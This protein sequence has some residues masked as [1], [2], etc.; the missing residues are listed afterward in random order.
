MPKKY[1]RKKKTL[2]TFHSARCVIQY[3][4][5]NMTIEAEGNSMDNSFSLGSMLLGAASAA[6]QVEG[7]D[8]N[9]NWYEWY[10]KGHIKDGSDP[11][12]ATL[13]WERWRED[14]DLMAELGLRCCRLGLEWSRIEPEEGVFSADAMEHYRQELRYLTSLGIRPMVTLW[15]FVNPL[16]FERRGAFLWRG[17]K[18]AF[19]TYVRRVCAE[20]GEDV[21]CWIT[22]NEPNVYAV[23]GY[24]GGG[25]PPGEND[26]P[27]LV[28]VMNTLT[29][30][31][32]GAY[33]IIHERFPD[34]RV[35]FA[36]HAR[37]FD[38]L[39]ETNPV[40][41]AGARITEWAFQTAVTRAMFTGRAALPYR[42]GKRGK[43][44]DYI[45]VNYYT[46]SSCSGVGDGVKP[47]TPKNDLDW[48]IYPEGLS[49]VIVALR[50]DYPAPV[51]ITEN[52]TC[53]KDDTFRCRYLYD[54]LR[55]LSAC[56][57]KPER[58]YHWCFCDNFEWLEGMSARFGL[59]HTDTATQERTVKKSGRF[60][61]EIIKNGGVTQEMYEKY[62]ES[63][64]YH[65]R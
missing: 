59:V 56:G 11:S 65:I 41:R 17:A 28:K 61:A 18:D 62:V 24:F 14:A 5:T 16:W 27:H 55:T 37:V 4:N 53:D 44:Y 26:L 3:K 9:N 32:I 36:L 63:E 38:P 29:D 21:E 13:H 12:V 30:C 57:V 54:H 2:L 40:H 46:R 31:H 47:D 45:A 22:L 6:T 52:G 50:K 7:G 60:Y 48:E 25:W 15:H 8:K 51:Y 42:G 49:R 19:L 43:Y 23:N 64:R 58:Y 39:D 1:S 35:S 33:N 34:A 20:L 10:Q